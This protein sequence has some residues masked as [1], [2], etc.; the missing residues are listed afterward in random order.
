MHGNTGYMKWRRPDISFIYQGRM[1]VLE[2]QK[3]DHYTDF[4]VDR[5]RFY[6]LN[7]VQV[8]WILE[9]IVIFHMNI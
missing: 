1:C 2:L 6:R 7:G 3:K 9:V 5:D 8:L 4:I